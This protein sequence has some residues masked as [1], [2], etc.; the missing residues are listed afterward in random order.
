MIQKSDDSGQK[1]EKVY[2]L[3]DKRNVDKIFYGL[4]LVGGGLFLADLL[5]HKHVNFP[6]EGW[7]GFFAW[8]GFVACVSLVLA[9]KGLRKL[10]KRDMD[11][12]EHD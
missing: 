6:F 3:D 2:W 8:Y 10:V 5:Y 11:Y 9:A 12:Y 1:T 7:F 4:V